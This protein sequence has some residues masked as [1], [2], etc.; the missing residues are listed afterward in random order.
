[1]LR[2]GLRVWHLQQLISIIIIYIAGKFSGKL[3]LAVWW[4]ITTAKLESAKISYSHVIY[5]YV[6]QSHTE[7]P[8]LIPANISGYMV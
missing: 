3:N 7:P 2:M 4:Y 5:M 6:W 1:M 8:N